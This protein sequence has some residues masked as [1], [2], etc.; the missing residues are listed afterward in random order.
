MID[1]QSRNRLVAAITRYMNEE[2]MAFAFD[3][4]IHQII[5]ATKDSTVDYVVTSLWYHYDDCKDHLAGLSKEEWDYFQRL[6][7]LLESNSEIERVSRRRWSVR[8]IVAAVA[9]LCFGL[10]VMRLG[11][12]WHLLAVAVLFGPISVLLSHWRN[13]SDMTQ[14]QEQL[15]LLPFS[16]FAELRAVRKTVAGFSKRQYPSHARIRNVHGPLATMAAWMN[17]LILW[18][19]GSPLVLLFHALPE[20]ETTTRIREGTV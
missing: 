3:D 1:R 6:I 9:L 20:K 17:L 15:S 11:I 2:I 19:I 14:T 8:Q 13:R 10:C 12:G 18:S 7:L 4:E 5:Y 16:S